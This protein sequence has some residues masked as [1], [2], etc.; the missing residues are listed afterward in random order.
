M[1]IITL[2]R[3]PEANELQACGWVIQH[4]WKRWREYMVHTL[5]HLFNRNNIKAIYNN[6]PK[7]V[8]P[9]THLK[10]TFKNLRK[11]RFMMDRINRNTRWHFLN[12]IFHTIRLTAFVLRSFGKAQKYI[13]IDPTILQSAKNWLISR[14][15]SNGCFIT[16]G[17]LFD[18]RMKVCSLYSDFL[19]PTSSFV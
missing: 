9:K 15:D 13:F 16:Q 11:S 19:K 18:N 8:V 12:H 5:L 10:H 14:Q 2:N 7:R 17:T 3:I 6:K 1:F 4:I